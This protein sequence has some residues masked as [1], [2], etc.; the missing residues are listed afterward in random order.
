MI[1]GQ[2][3]KSTETTSWSHMCSVARLDRLTAPAFLREWILEGCFSG[4]IFKEQVSLKRQPFGVVEQLSST[5]LVC[6]FW[7]LNLITLWEAEYV[8]GR[9]G[10]TGRRGKLRRSGSDDLKNGARLQLWVWY[11]TAPPPNSLWVMFQNL[12]QLPKKQQESCWKKEKEKKMI[13]WINR[14]VL[15]LFQLITSKSVVDK[16]K[17]TH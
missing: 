14:P 15:A 8:Y 5:D 4:N 2:R 6:A 12:E 11:A 10:E 1:E 16:T 13:R 9:L 7:V 3:Y 17:D